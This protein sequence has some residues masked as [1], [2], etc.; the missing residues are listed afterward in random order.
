MIIASMDV[1]AL[2]PS[3]NIKRSAEEV[4]K[5]MEE[6]DIE[7]DNVDY[8]WAG[9]FIASNMSQEDINLE[10]LSNIVPRRRKIFGVRPGSTT[11]ELYSKKEYTE[12]RTEK[13]GKSKWREVTRE[14]SAKEKR[15]LLGKVVE[16]EVTI[17][18]K[19]HV[20]QFEGKARVQREGEALA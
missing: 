12:E 15:K 14:L 2:Y 6:T 8:K 18:M 11:Q 4:R 5:E 20:Y 1:V 16:I 3:L 10:G 19:N 7:Y 17:L 13:K 9:K